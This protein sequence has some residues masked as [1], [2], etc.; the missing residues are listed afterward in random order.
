MDWFGAFDL[1]H[2]R[3]LLEN[4]FNKIIPDHLSYPISKNSDIQIER[5]KP[6]TPEP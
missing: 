2:I 1:M 3:T 4:R 6:S 5:P